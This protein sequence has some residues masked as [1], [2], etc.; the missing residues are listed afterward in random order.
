MGSMAARSAMYN[1]NALKIGLFGTNCSSGR[2]ITR[3][4]ERWSGT[5]DDNLT[6]ARMADAAGIDFLLPIA[7]FKG[8]GGETDY[9]GTTLE[10]LTW[11]SALLAHT[12]RLTIFGTVHTPLFHPLIAAKQVVTADYVSR[13]RMGLNVV[14]GWNENEFAMFG[15][16]KREH[17]ARYRHGQ[18]WLDIIKRAWEIDDFD[19]E[20]EFFALKGVRE[21]PKP[22][23]GSRPLIMNAGNSG[24]GRAFALRNCDAFFTGSSIKTFA[25]HE[26]VNAARIVRD[27]K[28]E[29]KAH[30]RDLDVYTV[31]AVVCRPTRADAAAFVDY[32]TDDADVAVIDTMASM[33]G[34]TPETEAERQALRDN[35]VNGHSAI[36]MYG[37]P[38]DVAN[39]LAKISA[40]GFTGVAL[41]FVN[42][43]D[44]FPLFRDEVL[45][46]LERLGVRTPLPSAISH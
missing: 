10:T 14:C 26:L 35:F 44:D 3:I 32:F 43:I 34:R 12:E 23:G 19:F 37:D 27:A 25:D 29:A 8:H 7:R 38:D 15:I 24:A 40:A 4:S 1:A 9:Q 16:D 22:Y 36:K 17:E 28:A 46:R 11:A 31:G 5:W 20:G 45:P 6:V 39:S 41:N 21:K 33:L 18:E 13:G 2:T 30:A 42:F